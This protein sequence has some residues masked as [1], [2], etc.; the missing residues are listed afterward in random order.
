MQLE[1]N[2][3]ALKRTTRGACFLVKDHLEQSRNRLGL[4]SRAPEVRP[5]SELLA[6]ASDI[7]NDHSLELKTV[8]EKARTLG[9]L[10]DELI[11]ANPKYATV[12]CERELD[13]LRAILSILR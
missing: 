12:E 11:R 4:H 6:V 1:I 8:V 7:S 10:Y 3:D 13:K 5:L 2:E 9:P